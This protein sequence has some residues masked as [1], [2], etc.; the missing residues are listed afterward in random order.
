MDQGETVGVESR[1]FGVQE[2][3]EID[4]RAMRAEIEEDGLAVGLAAG[5]FEPAIGH[6][7]AVALR[8]QA[9][10]Q[11]TRDG[12]AGLH[13]GGI[14]EIEARDR[15]VH[16]RFLKLIAAA[17]RL[18]LAGSRAGDRKACRQLDPRFR[19]WRQL[20]DVHAGELCIQPPARAVEPQVRARPS[21][22]ECEGLEPDLQR[23]AVRGAR[24]ERRVLAPERAERAA[25]PA[26]RAMKRIA[27]DFQRRTVEREAGERTGGGEAPDA[28]GAQRR[29]SGNA[30]FL[31]EADLETVDAEACELGMADRQA[32][33][34]GSLRLPGNADPACREQECR[35][36][37]SI[38]HP[39]FALPP[40]DSFTSTAAP[41]SSP[42]RSL[43]SASLA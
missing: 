34:A 41:R 6:G 4:I 13:A 37:E 43:A 3:R 5:E 19:D 16:D 17:A 33:A 40:V 32:D 1:R 24:A 11:Q 14:G 10:A 15:C 38:D 20:R 12:L 8:L 28:C 18:H 25:Q 29:D 36:C 7:E 35:A 26:A 27:G 39:S 23:P 9:R 31:R 42:R 21:A 30:R 2:S 22:R